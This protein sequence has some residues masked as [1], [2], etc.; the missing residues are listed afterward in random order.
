M[1]KI[2][3]SDKKHNL[4]N[5]EKKKLHRCANNFVL[6]CTCDIEYVCNQQPISNLPASFHSLC[7]TWSFTHLGVRDRHIFFVLRV[8]NCWT[9]QGLSLFHRPAAQRLL[10]RDLSEP[11]HRGEE[12]LPAVIT[13][14]GRQVKPGLHAGIYPTDASLIIQTHHGK[15]L[16]TNMATY[17]H[18]HVTL[19]RV[20]R[21]DT[22]TVCIGGLI[23]VLWGRYNSRWKGEEAPSQLAE[24]SAL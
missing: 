23:R 11:Q 5:L 21:M 8:V 18:S 12:K 13:E 20:S 19:T 2:S 14:D 24:V 22:T 17:E 6:N 1:L 15:H 10:V 4:K 9:G 3:C 16:C 7:C